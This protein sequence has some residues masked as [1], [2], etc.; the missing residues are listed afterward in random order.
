MY[1]RNRQNFLKGSATHFPPITSFPYRYWEP[2]RST[3]LLRPRL[4][5]LSLKPGGHF[6]PLWWLKLA[7]PGGHWLGLDVPST[8]TVCGAIGGATETHGDLW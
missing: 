7:G 4:C 1:T 5:A 6:Q 3:D 2:D 8:G